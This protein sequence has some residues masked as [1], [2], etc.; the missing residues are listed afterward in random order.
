MFPFPILM[1]HNVV[2]DATQSVDLS[3]SVDKL[4]QQF[5][6]LVANKYTTFH[7]SELERLK[8][9][10]AKSV[11]LVFDDVTENQIIFAQ[12]LLKKYNLKATFCIPFKYIGQTDLWNNGT[13]KIMSLNQLK[14]LDANFIE[15]G[16]HSFAHRAYRSLKEEEINEDFDNCYK[17]I[18]EAR[19]NVFPVLAYPFGN[20]PKK[21]IA[22][23]EFKK[24]LEKNNIKFGLRIG[25]R[26]SSFPFKDKFEIKRIDIKG[27]DSLLTFKIKLRIGKLSLF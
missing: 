3:I 17:I 4:E 26:P 20:F 2:E 8:K 19:L 13:E 25:N 22:N 5:K 16:H 1:Y 18:N 27:Q 10:P 7:F 11:V 15:L 12:P 24:A 6:Y 21:G 9:I 14:S 23:T